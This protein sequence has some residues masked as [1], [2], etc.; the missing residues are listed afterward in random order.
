MIDEKA[1]KLELSPEEVVGINEGFQILMGTIMKS[2]KFLLTLT[3]LTQEQMKEVALLLDIYGSL[4]EEY[5]DGSAKEQV[6]FALTKGE[7][8]N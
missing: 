7:T 8:K 6:I 4:Y 1:P 5:L 2:N 3:N